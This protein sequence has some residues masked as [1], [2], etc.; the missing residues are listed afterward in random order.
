M[1]G[2]GGTDNYA[3]NII[4]ALAGLPDFLR[5]P[6]LR[7]RMSEFPAL[8][9]DEQDEMVGHAL[10]A[11]PEIPFPVFARLFGTWLEVLADMN[12]IE[13]KSILGAY[14]RN[15]VAAPEQMAALHMDGL[16]AVYAKMQPNAQELLSSTVRHILNS[17]NTES[18]RRILIMTPDTAK[19]MLCI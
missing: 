16:V 6:I 11:S 10:E 17:M 19:S 1:N 13:R 7:R 5:K 14:A 3:G 12:E 8:P 18:R 9:A 2:Y 4:A 15:I